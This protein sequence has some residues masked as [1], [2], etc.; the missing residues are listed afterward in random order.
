MDTCTRYIVEPVTVPHV[1]AGV[2]ETPVALFTGDVKIGIGIFMVIGIVAVIVPAG[3]R[4]VTTAVVTEPSVGVPEM[5]PV[6]AFIDN[7]AGKPIAE[8]VHGLPTSV[9]VLAVIAVPAVAVIEEEAY[10]RLTGGRIVSES[11]VPVVSW[12]L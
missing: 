5:A 12:F 3:L 1:R 6:A 9:A 10:D 4:A 11:A 7:P 8:Y 2:S